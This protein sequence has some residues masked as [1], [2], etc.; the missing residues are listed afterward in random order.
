MK[1]FRVVDTADGI[2][3]EEFASLSMEEIVETTYMDEHTQSA[4]GLELIAGLDKL[5]IGEVFTHQDYEHTRLD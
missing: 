1:H 3:T 5:A 4:D 2:I